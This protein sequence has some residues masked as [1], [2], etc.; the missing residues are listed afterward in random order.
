MDVE[1]GLGWTYLYMSEARMDHWI[2]MYTSGERMDRRIKVSTGG[3]VN[4]KIE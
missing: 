1:L 4:F 2:K 3:K